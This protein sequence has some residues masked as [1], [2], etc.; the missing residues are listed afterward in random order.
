MAG[1]DQ[2]AR[3]STESSFRFTWEMRKSSSGS[4]AASTWNSWFW[5]VMETLPVGT[6]RTGWFAPW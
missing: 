5:L 2:L 6:W 3:P 4:E 1:S